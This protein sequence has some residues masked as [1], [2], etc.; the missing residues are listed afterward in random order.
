MAIVDV[1]SGTIR[2]EMDVDL[3]RMVVSDDQR[4]AITITS[5]SVEEAENLQA[6]L[7]MKIE[8]VRKALAEDGA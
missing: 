8:G 5:M 6:L 4:G 7:G 3:V 1:K 2:V